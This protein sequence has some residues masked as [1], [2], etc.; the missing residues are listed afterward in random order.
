MKLRVA[1]WAS[2]VCAAL[3]WSGVAW[4]TDIAPE[5]QDVELASDEIEHGLETLPRDRR[6]FRISVSLSGT[7]TKCS[8]GG[9]DLTGL[10]AFRDPC[11]DLPNVGLGGEMIATV[12]EYGHS[13]DQAPE[14]QFLDRVGDI[15]AGKTQLIRDRFRSERAFGQVQQRVDLGDRT[16]DSPLASEI[17]P[18][19]N[20][21]RHSRGQRS[22]IVVY[23]CHNRIICHDR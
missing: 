5:P 11:H 13:V 16:I 14:E 23:F 18:M 22:Y 9:I 10:S 12:A 20:E 2:A 3:G 6:N 4:A 17:A 8:L 1:V 7:G 19:E 15:R 21:A